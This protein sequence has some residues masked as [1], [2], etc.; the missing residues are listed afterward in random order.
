MSD[1]RYE[2]TTR[3]GRAV[4]K[5]TRQALEAAE[6]KCGYPLLVVQGSWSTS[7]SASGGTHAGAGVIDLRAGSTPA[8]TVKALRECGFAA[9][10]RKVGQ[11]PWAEHIHAVLIGNDHAAPAAKAQVADYRAGRNG[12]ANH[13][14]DDGPKVAFRQAEYRGIPNKK[15][16]SMNNVE[17][18]RQLIVAG[19]HQLR[20]AEKR[21]R[22][23]AQVKEIEK[24]LR[25][26]PSK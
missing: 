9:W 15:R 2:R 23:A 5:W 24:A 7:V 11:G 6:E 14:P 26:M 3:D 12:L 22:V 13:A 10:H 16:E 17:Y 4:D 20:L 18:G 21:P 8:V 25:D 19:L 1:D